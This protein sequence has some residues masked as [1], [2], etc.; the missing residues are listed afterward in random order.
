[1][2]VA[3]GEGV[4][5]MGKDRCVTEEG[6]PPLGSPRLGPSLASPVFVPSI[7]TPGSATASQRW[8]LRQCSRGV[9]SVRPEPTRRMPKALLRT[10]AWGLSS[11]PVPLPVLGPS[12]PPERPER[13]GPESTRAGRSHS[14]A[15]GAWPP[16]ACPSFLSVPDQPPKEVLSQEQLWPSAGDRGH[17]SPFP[18]ALICQ[19]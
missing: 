7:S 8:S 11:E 1:M 12:D 3:T 4:T 6:V 18:P 13:Q 5:P 14:P 10:T 15:V 17:D 2:V 19:G 16:H 9:T